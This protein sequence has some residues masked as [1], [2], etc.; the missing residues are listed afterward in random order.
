MIAESLNI[1]KTVVLLI[2]KK[3]FCSEDLFSLHNNAPTHKAASVYQ[4]F[5]QKM[6]EPCIP[7]PSLQIYLCQTTWVIYGFMH[8]MFS[9]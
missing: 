4:F 3:D 6:L 9:V 5:I 1:P 8:T 7:P 2:L